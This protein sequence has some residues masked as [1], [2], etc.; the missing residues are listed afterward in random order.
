MK[1]LILNQNKIGVASN[2]DLLNARL[3]RLFFMPIGEM[4]GNLDVGSRILDYF[5]E[6][7]TVENAQA[8]LSEVKLLVQIFEPA[9]FLTKTLVKF[10]PT[11]GGAIGLIIELEAQWIDTDTDPLNLKFIRVKD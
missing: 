2:A 9:I 6:G 1:G 4:I 8:I 3:E 7:D 11:T 10:V 5:H